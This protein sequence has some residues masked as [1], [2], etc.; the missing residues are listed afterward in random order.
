MRVG[1]SWIQWRADSFP[2][3]HLCLHVLHYYDVMS[4]LVVNSIFNIHNFSL[5]FELIYHCDWIW[6]RLSLVCICGFLHRMIRIDFLLFTHHKQVALFQLDFVDL[7]I[8]RC[9]L[10][11]F[12]S[13]CFNKTWPKLNN[14]LALRSSA[15][16]CI[17]L[18]SL[19]CKGCKRINLGNDVCNLFAVISCDA[20]HPWT[21][22]ER[23]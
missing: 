15:F 23:Q 2:I 10:F 16:K 1:F 9:C 4:D 18:S 13:I 17:Q 7:L 8:T 20:N 5:H 21:S 3:Q 6:A 19:I 12:S 11:S 14:N 22:R